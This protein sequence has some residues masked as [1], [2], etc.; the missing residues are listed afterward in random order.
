MAHAVVRIAADD[1]M[2]GL[3]ILFMIWLGWPMVAPPLL[4][5]RSVRR[6]H[7]G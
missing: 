1:D 4:L 7:T 6:L 2:G 5:M 3:L